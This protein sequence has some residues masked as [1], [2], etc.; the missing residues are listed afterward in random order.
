[1]PYSRIRVPWNVLILGAVLIVSGFLLLVGT[2]A[3]LL[4]CGEPYHCHGPRL[5]GAS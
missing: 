1:M 2:G 4:R 5:C 3:L